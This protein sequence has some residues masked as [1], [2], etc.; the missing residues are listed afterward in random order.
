MPRIRIELIYR[1]LKNQYLEKKEMKIKRIK[2]ICQIN[3]F[4]V[5]TVF[6]II[7]LSS[8]PGE[9]WPYSACTGDAPCPPSDYTCMPGPYEGT[10]SIR[11]RQSLN[12][13]ACEPSEEEATCSMYEW[14]WEC[15]KMQIFSDAKCS[16]LIGQE[17]WGMWGCF[18]AIAGVPW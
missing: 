14:L 8:T 5:L 3:G 1:Q 15:G 4:F 16:E 18:R 7:G 6:L 10:Y 9:G 12:Y 17:P 13:A 2:K 11:I